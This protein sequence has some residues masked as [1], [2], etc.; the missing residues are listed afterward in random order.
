MAPPGLSS[1]GKATKPGSKP[2]QPP[3][4]R[5]TTPLPTVR[6]SVE[7]AS[8]SSSYF[9]NRLSSYLKKCPTTVED[10]LDGGANGSSIPSGK[11]LLLMRDNIEKTVLKNV[12]SRCVQSE[13]ALRELMNNKKNRAPRERG[14]DKD[15]DDRERKQKLK[16]VSKKHDE[17]G[18][19]P[20]AIG[21]H[22]VARQDGGDAK[23][24][25]TNTRQSIALPCDSTCT[26][27]LY[28]RYLLF[29]P[30]WLP[31]AGS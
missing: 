28:M 10:I 2:S 13:G 22:G 3:R 26:I 23:G 20:P 27:T 31:S 19:H 9:G 29:F 21:A 6:A 17:D 24:K 8:S 25:S 18:K 30:T 11:Q 1:K 7:P 16:K 15:G 4:S 14:K 5:N 12:E